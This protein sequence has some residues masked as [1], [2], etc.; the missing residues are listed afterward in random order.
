MDRLRFRIPDAKPG[1]YKFAIYC[2]D[3]VKGPEGALIQWPSATVRQRARLRAQGE[4]LLRILP[5]GNGAADPE[6]G[7]SGIPS[8]TVGVGVGALALIGLLVVRRV[9]RKS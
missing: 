9:A 5:A 3:C 6:P 7:P 1:L 4:E 2:K 8:W